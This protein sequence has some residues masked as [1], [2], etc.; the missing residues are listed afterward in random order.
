[1]HR[2]LNTF[3]LGLLLV[4]GAERAS[5]FSL[6]GPFTSWQTTTIG[7]QLGSDIGGPMNLG[8]EYRWNIPLITYGFDS[9]F[10]NYFG[11]NGVAQIVQAFQV[12]N[13]LKAFSQMDS[14]LSEYPLET[15]RFNYQ[16]EALN[17]LSLRTEMMGLICEQ[18]GLAPPERYVWTLRAQ[19]VVNNVYFY[20]TIQRNFDPVTWEPSAYING[21]LYT[22]QIMPTYFNGTTP[23]TWEDVPYAVDPTL[24]N[25]SSVAGLNIGGG[26]IAAPG[27]IAT[28][29]P[30]LIF[31]GLTRDDVGGLRY[32]YLKSNLN[33]EVLPTNAVSATLGTTE[34]L[35]GTGT[36]SNPWSSPGFT[37]T[38]GTNVV[39]VTNAVVNQALRPG[40]DKFNFV[41]VQYDSLLGAWTTITNVWTD[42]Y[43][44]NGA[45]TSQLLQR[46]LAQ[47]DILI[48]AADLGVAANGVP[49]PVLITRTNAF[50][51]D[52]AI[53]TAGLDGPGIVSP[54]VSITFS[55][56]GESW[57]N[58]GD[59]G[60]GQGTPM[61]WWASFDISTNAPIV[62]PS[63]TSIRAIQDLILSGGGNAGLNPWRAP[64]YLQTNQT[65]TGTSPGTTTGGTGGGGTGG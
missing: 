46:T 31:T 62:F 16:A 48:G 35:I 32:I 60:Q 56:L 57:A 53:N 59:T 52:A 37:N 38:T 12:F 17:L 11:T 39:G 42:N 54:P 27:E 22:Y 1:M 40:I 14:S 15:R 43:V 64:A 7:Y 19:N 45:V 23:V 18:L 28:L 34:G 41:E 6:L 26:T 8:E 58:T 36:G 61:L 33:V 10:L 21:E 29:T 47:P 51:N 3:L 25:V 30:G 44:T 50:V 24:P 5:A 4:G 65:G 13:N 49:V 63:G 55:K 20:L 9:A 2:T